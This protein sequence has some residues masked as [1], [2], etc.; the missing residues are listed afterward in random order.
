MEL[1][2]EEE[3]ASLLVR[4]VRNRHRELRDEVRHNKDS[5]VRQY[6]QHKERILNRI[7]AKFPE[8]LDEKAHMRGFLGSE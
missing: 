8:E 3:E 6:L 4:V 2:L 5:E 1:H 7:L